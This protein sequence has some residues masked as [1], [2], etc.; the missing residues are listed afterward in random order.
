MSHSAWRGQAELPHTTGRRLQRAV[1]GAVQLV[2]A[3][4]Y[5]SLRGGKERSAS[6]PLRLDH[7]AQAI[8]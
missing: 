6:H 1:S 3:V 4:R 7:G 5:G 2:D 8:R